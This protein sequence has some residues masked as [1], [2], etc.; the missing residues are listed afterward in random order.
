MFSAHKIVVGQGSP[1]D[2]PT[3]VTYWLQLQLPLNIL[4]YS[5]KYIHTIFVD[6]ERV[7]KLL[8]EKPTIEDRPD[9]KEIVIMRGE[10]NFDHV[11]FSYDVHGGSSTLE[12]LTFWVLPGQT[13]AI[14]GESGGG[15]ST[16][17]RL[18]YRF[19]D[20]RS[21]L[22]SIDGQDISKVTVKSLRSS[23]G[24]IPQVKTMLEFI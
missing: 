14:V 4:G 20:I 12:K 2:L 3:L 19:Y 9:A 6:A 10:I 24:I 1:S 16:V 23:I 8:S 7:L 22:I 15:K 17:F 13:V 18:L 5:Y 11:D 21:G